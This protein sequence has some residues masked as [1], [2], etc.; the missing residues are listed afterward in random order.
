MKWPDRLDWIALILTLLAA[1][2]IA[3]L[4]YFAPLVAGLLFLSLLTVS[5]VWKRDTVG[6]WGRLRWFF[7]NLLSGW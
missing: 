3:A 7:R 1:A 5:A 2:V 4:V 6:K